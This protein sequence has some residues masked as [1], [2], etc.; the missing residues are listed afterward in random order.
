MTHLTI[1]VQGPQ[2]AIYVNGEPQGFVSDE[3]SKGAQLG[4]ALG[5]CGEGDAPL[6][7]SFDNLRV[8]DISGLPPSIAVP[9][10]ELG[11]IPIGEANT[12]MG[13]EL[14][15]RGVV[16]DNA[17]NAVPGVYVTLLVESGDRDMGKLG[18]WGLYTDETGSYA[19]IGLVRVEQGNYEVWFNGGHEYGKVYENSGYHIPIDTISGNEATLDVTVYPVTGSVLSGLIR[20]EDLDGSI[21]NFYGP[22]IEPRPDRFIALVR[23][24]NFDNAEYNIGSEYYSIEGNRLIV[25]GLAGGTYY[26]EFY[27]SKS[28]GVLRYCTSPALELPAGDTMEFDYTIR[29]CPPLME[30]G[31]SG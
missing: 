31:P 9:M 20:F 1:I 13:G 6:Q 10:P 29:D 18:D 3:A 23:G 30:T 28:D 5:V 21:K 19:F 4:L 12:S 2:L 16:R 22:G 7:V 8:W 11:G 25:P 15:I 24:A 14:S 26:L 27:F 17:G